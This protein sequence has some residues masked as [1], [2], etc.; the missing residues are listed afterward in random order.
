MRG[1]LGRNAIHCPRKHFDHDLVNPAVET[2][3]RG[4][5]T[6]TNISLSLLDFR[7]GFSRVIRLLTIERARCT[8]QETE[9]GYQD[10]CT[11]EISGCDLGIVRNE[12]N[13]MPVGVFPDVM[14]TSHWLALRRIC[15]RCLIP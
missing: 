9:F 5:L 10:S 6:L 3:S 12:L 13:V 7:L 8:P 2:V 1:I 4:R 15:A 11:G 14:R